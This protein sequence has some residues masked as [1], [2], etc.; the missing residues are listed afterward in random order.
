LPKK[1]FRSPRRIGEDLREKLKE[2]EPRSRGSKILSRG[3]SDRIS[4][5]IMLMQI[6]FLVPEVEA[7]VEEELSHVSHVVKMDIRPW[8]IQR[9]RWTEEMLTS[10]KRSRGVMSRAKMLT[11]EGRWECIRFFWHLRGR[12]TAQCNG[13]NCSERLVRPRTGNERS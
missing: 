8:T 6:H 10:L 3:D 11:A 12:W 5:E 7:E 4:K 1:E 2:V 13:V 9:G